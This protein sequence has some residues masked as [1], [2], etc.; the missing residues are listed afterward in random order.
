MAGRTQP[1]TQD[2]NQ[3]LVPRLPAIPF[4][5]RSMFPWAAALEAK[6]DLIRE[7]LKAIGVQPP[8]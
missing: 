7:E 3:L 6:T 2:A 8:S 5:D 1:Y 4:Y